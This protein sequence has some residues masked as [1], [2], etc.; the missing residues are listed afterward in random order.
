MR[1]RV[2]QTE[3]LT[4]PLS[5]PCVLQVAYPH[6]NCVAEVHVESASQK[7]AAVAIFN[8][9]ACQLFPSQ[10]ETLGVTHTSGLVQIKSLPCPRAHPQR[11]GFR[12]V[13]S[14]TAY[15]VVLL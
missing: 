2:Q 5:E 10:S 11:A 8:I 4:V 6:C 14:E 3:T 1:R 12:R 13:P 15:T 9:S 7:Q